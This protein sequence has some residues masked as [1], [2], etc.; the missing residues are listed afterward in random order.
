MLMGKRWE[1]NA[2]LGMIH[3]QK[4]LQN[5]WGQDN[6]DRYD[7]EMNQ[8]EWNETSKSKSTLM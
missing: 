3:F 5:D 8:I 7:E 2:K 4:Q 1:L 6:I